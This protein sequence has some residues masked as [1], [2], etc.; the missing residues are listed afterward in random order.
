M[1]L[2]LLIKVNYISLPLTVNKVFMLYI[3][4]MVVRSNLCSLK[5]GISISQGISQ[6]VKIG[7]ISLHGECS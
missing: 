4:M 7:F 1:N 2:M 3:H 5:A 6:Q